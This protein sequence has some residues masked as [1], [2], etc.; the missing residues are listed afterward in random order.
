MNVP[1]SYVEFAGSRGSV[2]P[3]TGQSRSPRHKVVNM[4]FLN[5]EAGDLGEDGEGGIE[6]TSLVHQD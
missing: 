1:N 6:A 5:A 3:E 2:R 4:I